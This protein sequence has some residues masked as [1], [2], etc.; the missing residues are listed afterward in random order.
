M[1]NTPVELAEAH[2]RCFWPESVVDI[3]SWSSG[4]IQRQLPGFTVA[5][6]A[7]AEAG[8]PWVFV[9]LG[10]VTRGQDRST[11]FMLLTPDGGDE[12][13]ES[14]AVVSSFQ[15]L[16]RERTGV[17]EILRLG[18]PWAE[19]AAAEHFAVSLP[20]PFGPAFEHVS[21]DG[22]AIRLLWLVPITPDEVDYARRL[23]FEALER[24]LDAAQPLIVDPARASVVS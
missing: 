18:R 16:H 19:G 4:P 14:L 22:L 6:V 10:D 3:L 23:G 21:R 2:I 20:Y 13:I 11:E 15:Q 7:P 1:K 5:R 24:A 9:S 8:D 12:H 17:G